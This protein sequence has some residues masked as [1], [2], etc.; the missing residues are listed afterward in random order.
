MSITEIYELM[1]IVAN[2]AGFLKSF[3]LVVDINSID[4]YILGNFR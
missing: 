3:M 1:I 4:V 2:S